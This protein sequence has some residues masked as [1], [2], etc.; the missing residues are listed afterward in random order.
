MKRTWK[1][2]ALLCLAAVLTFLAMGSYACS[3]AAPDLTSLSEQAFVGLARIYQSG[4]NA[5]DSVGNLNAALSLIQKASTLRAA[6][7]GTGAVLLEDQ[8]RSMLNAIIDSTP[9]AQ[10][11]AATTSRDRTLSV[12]A[13]VPIAVMISTLA[14]Y[15]GL[16]IWRRHERAKL[17]EMEIS[18]E[19]ETD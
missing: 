12:A 4:G 6:G 18:Y 5:P 8:A 14:F 11:Q 9:A 10:Q 16:K 1:V 15:C 19:K 7:N 13:S 17:F 3:Q 2:S